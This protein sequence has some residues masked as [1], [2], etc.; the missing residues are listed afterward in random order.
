MC[1]VFQAGPVFSAVF[2]AVDALKVS[3]ATGTVPDPDLEVKGFSVFGSTDVLTHISTAPGNVVINGALEVSSDVYITG[4]STFTG[5]AFFV[6]TITAAVVRGLET[7]PAGDAAASKAYVDSALDKCAPGSATTDDILSGKSAD[8][9]CDNFAE[10]GTMPTQTLSPAND[11]VNAGYYNATTLAAVDADLAAG[12]IKSGVTIFGV[13]GIM[14]TAP[15]EP[16]AG[17]AWLLVPG[18]PDLGT[19]DFWVQ[20]YEAKNVGSVATSQPSGTPWVSITQISAKT[21]CEA[22]GQGYH[23]LTMREVLAISRNIENN[24]WNWTGGSVGSGGLWRGHTDGVPNN[25]L[26]ADVTGDPDDDYY[27]ETG[28]TTPSIERRVHQLSSGQYIWDWSGDVWEW[29]DMTCTAGTG[30]GYWYNSGA[31]LEWTDGNL[32]DYEKARAGPAGAYTA[33]HNAGRYFGCSATGNA[34]LRSGYFFTGVHAGVFAFNAN[35]APSS[36]GVEIGFRCGR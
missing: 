1:A 17:G 26:A 23:L 21:Y 31:Y 24:G 3:G 9:D 8:I 30:A 29:V 10:A 22:L 13:A 5:A 2:N 34:V 28:N 32:S 33:T 35:S 12:N 19:L 11:T 20:K 4:R 7:P 36:S 16:T 15:P 27:A 25:S 6:S 18:D 14:P